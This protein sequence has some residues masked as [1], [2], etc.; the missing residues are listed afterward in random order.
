MAADL[1]KLPCAYELISVEYIAD[2]Q[3]EAYIL[4]HKKSCARVV[5]LANDDE[6]K[7]FSISFRTPPTDSTGVA[8]I[9]EH[10]VLCGSA[11]FPAKDPFTEL[12]K[13]SLNTF[14]NAITY[15]DKTV[16]PVASCNDK[17][18]QNLMHVYLDAVFQPNIYAREE[19]FK[20][21]GW[22]Y[23]LTDREEPII[24][25]GVVYNEMKGAFS[26]PDEV[27]LRKITETLYPDTIYSVE[28]GGDPKVIPQLSYEQFLDFHRRYYHPCNSYIYLYGKMDFNEKL[29]FMDRE[30]LQNFE[31]L[32]V[33]SSIGWQEA[34]LEPV[35]CRGEYPI[36][37]GDKEENAAYMAYSWSIGSSLD[38]KLYMAFQILQYV[39]IDAP[40]AVLKQALLDRELGEDIYGSFETSMRQPF[41]SIIIKNTD[42][43][44]QEEIK[45]VIDAELQRLID[46]G[47]SHTSL[48]G[49]L[50]YFEFKAR[51]LDFG[52]W[53]MGLLY[54]LQMMHSWLY[55]DNQ[56][57]IHL[58]FQKLYDELNENL[59][60][61]YFEQ[62]IRNYLLENK[63]ASIYVMCPSK[64]LTLRQEEETKKELAAYK[65]QLSEEEIEALIAQTEALKA[66]QSKPTPKEILEMIPT[67]SVSD[68]RKESEPFNNTLIKE[69]DV[70]ILHHEMD[71]CE[72]AYVNLLFDVGHIPANEVPYL[73]ILSE[74][75]GNMDTDHYT[76]QALNDAVNTY[77]GGMRTTINVYEQSENETY[78]PMF[79]FCGKAFY[80]KL[81]KL[82]ALYEEML[83]HTHFEDE[84]RLKEILNQLKSRLEMGL[85]G[86]G[87]STAVNRATSY[88]HEAAWHK[89]LTGGIAFYHFVCDTLENYDE[90]KAEVAQK[91]RS[92]CRKIFRKEYLLA[93][94]TADAKGG[95]MC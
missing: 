24:Y 43:E 66:Y 75:L 41:L 42:A 6:N 63:H 44:R 30:Y 76:Y 71:T 59:E 78:R 70:E 15:H 28:S 2:I 47:L 73:G 1:K 82:F 17:D 22:H 68:I 52:Q 4:R 16:Y 27:L 9:M 94:V 77:T 18:F 36:G 26:S 81:P 11:R 95:D 37:D 39:L 12:S 13:S 91:V 35:V 57:I 5:A 74:M 60:K 72:V 67:L 20:Q 32:Q 40:G 53:P 25:N 58:K 93:D 23:E 55:E 19:I 7:V 50:N 8:H 64:G 49:T 79:E 33:D 54:G 3:S 46:G 90:R 56:P 80:N 14:L 45:A 87:H 86:N 92:I 38:A 29:D 48:A 21:E 10:S 51:E 31:A 85:L 62:L 89:E 83:V 65:E 34:F 84:K 61:N 88:F 69:E